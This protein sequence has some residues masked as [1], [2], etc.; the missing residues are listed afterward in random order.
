METGVYEYRD[1]NGRH[2]TAILYRETKRFVFL[3]VISDRDIRYGITVEKIPKSK[4]PILRLLERNGRPYPVKRA[5]R[6]FRSRADKRG[7]TKG[8]RLAMRELGRS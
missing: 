5:L 1:D 7:A 8:A 4:R 3:L 6:R 2:S